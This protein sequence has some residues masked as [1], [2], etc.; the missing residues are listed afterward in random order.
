MF[1][2]ITYDVS[3]VDKAGRSRLRKVARACLNWGQRVQY[4]VFEV[5][6]SKPQWVILRNELLSLIDESRDS[7]RF[8]ILEADSRDSLEHHGVRRPIDLAGPLIV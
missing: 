6:L 2:L 4:S 1:V 7:I 3:T 8:Y 5:E